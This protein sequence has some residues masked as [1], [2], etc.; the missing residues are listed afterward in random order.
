M[1]GWELLAA[2]WE[3][4]VAT[5]TLDDLH[6]RR[7]KYN[8]AWAAHGDCLR[9]LTEARLRGEAPP[10]NLVEREA[11]ARRALEF[12]SEQL[13]LAITESITGTHRVLAEHSEADIA[14][15]R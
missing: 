7:L 10:P 13:R 6:T 15:T 4:T 12:A 5:D 9:S 11:N 8:V 3:R 14:K 2:N 1:P